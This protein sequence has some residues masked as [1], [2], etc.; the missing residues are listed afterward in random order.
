[1]ATI[2]SR[3]SLLPITLVELK[4]FLRVTHTDEDAF[5]TQ[6]IKNA[7]A[8]IEMLTNEAVT[9]ATYL[10]YFDWDSELTIHPRI[11]NVH[12]ITL[13]EYLNSDKVWTTVTS[14]FEFYPG[15][16]P[17]YFRIIS[18]LEEDNNAGF[19]AFASAPTDG[20]NI[21]MTYK[22]G[23]PTADV[24]TPH[25]IDVAYNYCGFF[26]ENRQAMAIPQFLIE[27][28]MINRKVNVL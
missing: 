25:F 21:R 20:P 10:E 22:A 9:E 5:L 7:R 27:H 15:E 13:F 11:L 18:E 16:N 1:M 14:P 24:I 2:T 26:Y 12:T 3:I 4:L 8:F 6:M 28:A 23:A 17:P 19:W